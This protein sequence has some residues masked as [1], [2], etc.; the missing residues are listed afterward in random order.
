MKHIQPIIF[1][2]LGV[3]SLSQMACNDP[4]VIGSDLLSGDQLDIKFM[5]TLTLKAH[6]EPID[7]I[8]MYNPNV[9]T[10][11]ETFPLGKFADPIFGTATSNVYL[12]PS[13]N[14]NFP[15][16]DPSSQTLDS[17]VLILPF[18]AEFSYGQMDED[19]T[20]EVYQM[21]GSFP[22]TTLYSNVDL[23]THRLI[24]TTT[25]TPHP[26]DSVDV[27]SAIL[28]TLVLE[29]P[30]LR[31]RLDQNGFDDD[32]FNIDTTASNSVDGF[33]SFIKGL[34]IKPTSEN[35]GMPS[36]TFRTSN[37]G[38]RVYYHQDTLARDYRFPIFSGNVVAANFIHDRTTSLL[39]LGEDFIGENAKYPDS[40][41]FLQG[42]SG[43]NVV[44]EF[45]YVTD[46]DNIVVNKAELEL[47]IIRLDEDEDVY[48]PT[49]QIIVSE[50]QEDGSFRVIDDVT[51]AINRIG[52][53]RFSQLFGGGAESDNVYRLNISA[54]FQDMIRGLVTNKIVITTFP[55]AEQAA[56]SVL[57]GPG[58]SDKPT[59]LKLT[60]TNF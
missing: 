23:P 13:L 10:N 22:D 4:T 59:K 16:F 8:L 30:H 33:E 45:P 36:F 52:T 47:P 19:Y 15:D 1:L 48:T 9:F 5:D 6:N 50:V 24:G 53:D 40:L 27:F 7:S 38:I 26:E 17:V 55:K 21:E 18:N 31:I 58:N 42:M 56:R 49:T 32:L 37:S 12:Q 51:L 29:P 46:L 41:L 14:V 43:T 28:D 20:L 60:Y 44:L 35:K 11:T 39:N 25:Y 54:H 3:I 2:L 57:G 34:V